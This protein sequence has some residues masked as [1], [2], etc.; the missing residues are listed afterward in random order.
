MRN[1]Y[2][3]LGLLFL[4]VFGGSH[5]LLQKTA[6]APSFNE[7]SLVDS[8]ENVMSL[9]LS[10]PAFADNGRIPSEYTCD[11]EN[12]QPPL[13]IHGVPES[14][15]SLVL[16]MDD[17][18]IPA[19]VKEKMGIEKFNHWVVYNLPAD[20]REFKQRDA[21]GVLGRNTVGELAYTG[22]CPPTEYEP[23][24]HRYVFR[25]YALPDMLNFSN[26]PTLAEVETAAQEIAIAHAELIGRYSR[27]ER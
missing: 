13:S 19:E 21:L 15:Q 26:S 20:T 14:T 17:S 12:I 9:T 16:V 22:P 25:L 11:G 1:A 5:M 8:Q 24:E 6:Q 10:S 7:V 2:A 27:L 4:I 18:D 3:L 23:T